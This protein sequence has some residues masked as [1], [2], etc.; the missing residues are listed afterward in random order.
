V[1]P[2]VDIIGRTGAT[3]PWQIEETGLKVG[4]VGVGAMMLMK[5]SLGQTLMFGGLPK[6]VIV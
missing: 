5:V 6:T 1:I 4:I 3:F 2:F